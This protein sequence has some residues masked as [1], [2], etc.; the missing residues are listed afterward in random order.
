MYYIIPSH[1]NSLLLS[2]GDVVHVVYRVC[3][4]IVNYVGRTF[5]NSKLCKK[6]VAL[7]IACRT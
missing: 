4:E 5:V 6:L 2:I 1:S 7:R 3:Y